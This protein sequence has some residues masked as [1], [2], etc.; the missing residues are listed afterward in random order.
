MIR[1]GFSY[2]ISEMYNS[3]NDFP[4][5]FNDTWKW[6]EYSRKNNASRA[7]LELHFVENVDY[8][9]LLIFKQNS[10]GRPS[11][12][13]FLSCDCFKHFSMMSK[14]EGSKKVRNY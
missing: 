5:S 2:S 9:V 7:F 4:V 11:K 1:E 13:Y 10:E 12:D 8:I 3:S 14:S 6:L